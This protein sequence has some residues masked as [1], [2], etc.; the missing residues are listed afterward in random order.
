MLRSY[1]AVAVRNLLK[2][3]SDKSHVGFDFMTA[4]P[5]AGG[6]TYRLQRLNRIHLY[7]ETDFGRRSGGDITFLGILGL[8]GAFRRQLAG[9]FL[10]EAV[11]IAGLALVLSIPLSWNATRR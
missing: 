8:I 3:I 9:Q 5:P 4:H 10:G 7:S 1:L 11:L 2:H 6:S